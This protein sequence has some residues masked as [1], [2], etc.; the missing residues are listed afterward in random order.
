LSRNIKD[1]PCRIHAGLRCRV[2][3]PNPKSRHIAA[4]SKHFS[5]ASFCYNDGSSHQW[6]YRLGVRT[7][8]SQS[9]N[10]GSIPGSATTESYLQRNP[11]A[12]PWKSRKM[13]AIPH[14]LAPEP[15][16]RSMSH[17]DQSEF[18]VAFSGR[19]MS[20]PVSRLQSSECIAIINR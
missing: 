6:R 8:D 18:Y 10:P 13:P 7:E 17:N 12:F 11:P 16:R 3:L 15:D 20:S 2:A 14:N 19:Q 1:G 4:S 9:S 5:E